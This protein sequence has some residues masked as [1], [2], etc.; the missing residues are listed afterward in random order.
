M[1]FVVLALNVTW[2]SSA[3]SFARDQNY[4]DSINAE[5]EN[6]EEVGNTNV[7][8]PVRAADG[9]SS[10]NNMSTPRVEDKMDSFLQKI[11]S[12]LYSET[13]STEANE[14]AYLN[15]LE[16]EVQHLDDTSPQS[17]SVVADDHANQSEAVDLQQEQ[18]RVTQITEAQRKEMEIALESRI[19]GIF[20][21]YQKLGLT[22]RRLVVEEYLQNEK[23]ST[24]SKA[25][26]RL[27]GG[28]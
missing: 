24:A 4:L 27:Y 3:I 2:L 7:N 19:P 14:S 26:L 1:V 18:N 20:R 6:L 5:A 22:Q 23:I 13:P 16:A 28:Q 12:T 8:T 25:I 11:N 15:Q 17:A 21:L 10:A 9:N